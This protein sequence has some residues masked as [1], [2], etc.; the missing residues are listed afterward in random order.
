MRFNYYAP[1]GKKE[2]KQRERER[3]GGRESYGL[4]KRRRKKLNSSPTV[5][6]RHDMITIDLHL[7]GWLMAAAAAA[8]QAD[9]ILCGDKLK[10]TQ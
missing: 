3:E 7:G 1:I 8:G 10:H 9:L 2:E 4:R 5:A 6:V